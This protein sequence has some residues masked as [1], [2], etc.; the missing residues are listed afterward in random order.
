MPAQR[1]LELYLAELNEGTKG[2]GGEG[3]AIASRKKKEGLISVNSAQLESEPERVQTEKETIGENPRGYHA[4]VSSIIRGA[5][6]PSPGLVT[7]PKLCSI[8]RC[9][10]ASFQEYIVPAKRRGKPTENGE[11]QKET[12]AGGEEVLQ[13][14]ENLGKRNAASRTGNENLSE[15]YI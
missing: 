5:I 11:P 12:N 15:T 9:G 10:C 3:E 2:N 14:T 13:K 7:Q 6:K 4:R 1:E 8:K